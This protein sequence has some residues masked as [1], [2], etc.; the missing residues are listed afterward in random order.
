V[1][2]TGGH[3][4]G[5]RE[6]TLQKLMAPAVPPLHGFYDECMMKEMILSLGFLKPNPVYPYGSPSAFG[7]P[8]AGGSFGFADPQTEVGY[9]YVT[10]CLGA[11]QGSDPRE[12][13]L[14]DALYRSIGQTFAAN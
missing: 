6:E 7:T 12:L 4:L 8:G 1:F 13:A 10:N 11:K 14:R 9:A 2:A 3:E 5:L